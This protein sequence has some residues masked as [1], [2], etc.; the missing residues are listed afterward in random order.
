MA[1]L[2]EYIPL[3]QTRR[4]SFAALEN[5]TVY[6]DF[7]YLEHNNTRGTKKF[8]LTSNVAFKNR[9]LDVAVI[10]LKRG[11]SNFPPAFHT[12]SKA[13]PNKTFT[14]VG[15]PFGEVK[16]LN[17]TE[18]LCE[19]NEQNRR[20]LVDW[21][22][23]TAGIDGFAGIEV[24]ERILFHCSFEKGASGSPGVAV[25]DGRAVVVTMLLH[26]YPDWVYDPACDPAVKNQATNDR[27]IEQGVNMLELYN[28]MHAEDKDLCNAIFGTNEEQKGEQSTRVV[29]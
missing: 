5:N 18:G 4:G 6:V 1:P 13:L 7:E 19:I 17:E 11:T 24:R 10:E 23:H 15:H 9:V 29:G 26:G 12:F 2:S 27:R 22:R 8:Y 21:S 25:V 3:P 28:T 20:A 14:L 16:Q